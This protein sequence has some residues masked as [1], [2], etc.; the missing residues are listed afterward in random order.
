[1]HCELGIG[2]SNMGRRSTQ[3]FS[4][5]NL[6]INQAIFEPDTKRVP[7]KCQV[8]DC[9]FTCSSSSEL[10]THFSSCPFVQIQCSH[11]SEF[12]LGLTQF[13]HELFNC[14]HVLTCS[15]CKMIVGNTA[16]GPEPKHDC[17]KS[18]RSQIQQIDSFKTAIQEQYAA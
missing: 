17:R 7:Q 16:I 9:Q 8:K 3:D 18:L 1:M 15:E 5:G 2:I 14:E 11:C 10:A 6:L 13:T 4:Q 12:V